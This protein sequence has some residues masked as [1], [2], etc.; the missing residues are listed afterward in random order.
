MSVAHLVPIAATA[1]LMVSCDQRTSVQ[2]ANGTESCD[3]LKVREVVGTLGQRMKQVPLSAPDSIAARAIRENY[4]SLVTPG[5]LA[6]WISQPARAPGREVS[7]PWPER[8]EIR[9]VKAAGT[10]LCRVDG[11]VVYVT[12]AGLTRRGVG[13][14][15]P[16]SLLVKSDDGWHINAYESSTRPPTG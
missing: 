1:L 5:L 13:S 3:S 16:V 11:D 2:G 8:I 14:R 15:R 10:G 9:S 4:A 12:S 7:S 6:A